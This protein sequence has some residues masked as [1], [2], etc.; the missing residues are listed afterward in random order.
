MSS[1]RI[2]LWPLAIAALCAAGLGT[3]LVSDGW[4]DVLAWLGLAVPAVISLW[5]LLRRA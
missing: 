2:W 4:G 3:G 1:I 5:V